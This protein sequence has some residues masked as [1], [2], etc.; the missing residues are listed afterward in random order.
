MRRSS[1]L[2][3]L[4]ISV[5]IMAGGLFAADFPAVDQPSVDLSKDVAVNEI[6]VTGEGS[7]AMCD[8]HETAECQTAITTKDDGRKVVYY[9]VDNDVSSKFHGN[10]CKTPAR[11][12]ATGVVEVKDGKN[13]LTATKVS[14]AT[15]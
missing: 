15:Q 7:C 10:I 8:L 14:L 2:A 1:T 3:S 6:T 13:I 4:L 5:M 12:M 11:V 9:L